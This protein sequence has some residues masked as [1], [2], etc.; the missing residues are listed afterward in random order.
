MKFDA[1]GRFLKLIVLIGALW[2]L[3][4]VIYG[5]RYSSSVWEQANY[6]GQMVRYDIKDWFKRIGI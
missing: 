2:A 5:G 4:V 6:Q 3:D 1:M